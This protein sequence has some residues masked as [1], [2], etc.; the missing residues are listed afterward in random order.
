MSTGVQNK[1]ACETSA[2]TR[3]FES[4]IFPFR[5]FLAGRFSP[6]LPR[7]AGPRSFIFC[8]QAASNFTAQHSHRAPVIF[9]IVFD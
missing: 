2:F 7:L 4:L 6:T 8:L 3:K 9:A 1:Q 5:V